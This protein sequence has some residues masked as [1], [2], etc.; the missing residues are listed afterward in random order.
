MVFLVV[1][2]VLVPVRLGAAAV[3][4][5]ADRSGGRRTGPAGTRE[6]A[7][8][9]ARHGLGRAL[10]GRWRGRADPV[11]AGRAGPV[12]DRRAGRGRRHLRQARPA[13]VHPARP[14]AGGVRRRAGPA[15][16]PGRAGAVAGGRG[17]ARRPSSAGRSTR[18][19]P[20]S[21]RSR[22]PPPRSP[23]CTRPGWRRG[24]RGG[25]QG[26]AAGHPAGGRAGPR[27][28]ATG[29]PGRWPRARPG[30]GRS[31]C[32]SWPTASRSALREELDFR[33]EAANMAAVADGR[34]RPGQRP[35]P[36]AAPGA[37]HRAAAGDGAAGRGAAG[38][39]RPGHRRAR[40][41][42]AGAGPHA[43]GRPLLR[44]VM[45]DGV[46]HADPHPGNV[47]LLADGAAGAARLRLGRPA[48]HVTLR[49]ALRQLLLAID[50]ADPVA[51]SDALLEVVPRPDEID[52]QRLERAV[53]VVLARHLG[54]GGSAGRAAGRRPGPGGRPASGWRCRRRWPRCSGRWPRG[55]ARSPSWR[56]A[57]TWSPRPGGSPPGSSASSCGPRRRASWPPT[58]WSRCC[59]CCAGCRA[60]WTGS[61]ARWRP[62]G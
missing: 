51:V 44:Q 52:E 38:R 5:A 17:G 26:A 4:V 42:P 24:E 50:R 39:G 2:E 32:A 15:A 28:R 8:I 60:G 57:S 20:R 11:R 16:G 3:R 48:R 25:A 23:R 6:I 36:A 29:W 22:W 55:R 41:G 46:F 30:A 37:V 58:S 45:L 31:G 27:H 7:R 61:P 54:P 49:A 14:A 47:L 33:V 62:A 59:R 19:S 43:A 53:G 9:A 34:R 13:A 56:P 40:A 35:D 18:S 12:A 10:R 21:S 1:A